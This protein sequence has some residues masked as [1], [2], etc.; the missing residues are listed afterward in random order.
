[1]CLTYL[2]K[3]KDAKITVNNQKEQDEKVKKN[4]RKDGEGDLI[5][6]VENTS[7]K[8]KS[9]KSD[10]SGAAESC[11]NPKNSEEMTNDADPKSNK[12]KEKKEKKKKSDS[13]SQG[14]EQAGAD[15]PK[16]LANESKMQ[17]PDNK[18]R[19][20]KRKKNKPSSEPL[21]DKDVGEESKDVK[22][23]VGPKAVNDAE[24]NVEEKSDKPKGKKKKKDGISE[25]ISA[26][27]SKELQNRDSNGTISEK[28]QIKNSDE[29]AAEKKKDSK[30][31]ERLTSEEDSLQLPDKKAEEES[32]RRK[33][34]NSTES[35]GNEQSA[36][37]NGTLGSDKD[38]NKENVVKKGQDGGNDFQRTSSGQINRQANGNLKKTGEKSS[39]QKSL[40]K[41]HDNSVEPKTVK[42]FQ[43]VKVDVVEFVDERLKDNSYWAKDGADSGYGAKAQEVLGQVR[44]RD[45]R[46]EK[47]KKKRGTYRGG[48]IDLQSHS[49]KFNYSD[50]E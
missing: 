44:G 27:N 30:K 38:E 40:K 25:T 18:G 19:D 49:I 17:E 26:C 13:L 14:T 43:R 3:C 33:I 35:N 16:K 46:H 9:H 23:A 42:A 22:C 21:G 8:K 11:K 2:E 37:V 29:D 45:F 28:D 20:K 39:T 34:G 50:E 24:L 6:D 1:M 32:K 5:A 7:R 41:Q 48:L 31:R 4:S 12:S 15:V 47:T 36:K 10:Q